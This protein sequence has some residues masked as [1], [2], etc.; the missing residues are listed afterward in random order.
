M[1]R[2][3]ISL[4]VFKVILVSLYDFYHYRKNAFERL[5]KPAGKKNAFERMIGGIC[6]RFR[7]LVPQLQIYLQD[8]VIKRRFYHA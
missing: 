5:T 2:L 4:R 7:I 1:C 6:L 3:R 8:I